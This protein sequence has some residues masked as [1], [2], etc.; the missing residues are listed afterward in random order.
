M[1]EVGLEPTLTCVN[2]I[3]S[4]ARLPFRH[5]GWGL[6][7]DSLRQSLV[8]VNWLIHAD[9]MGRVRTRRVVLF[10]DHSFVR[11]SNTSGDS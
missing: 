3:L 1:P 6:E 2:W 8:C 11:A 5:S 9:A 7:F 10:T 4:P